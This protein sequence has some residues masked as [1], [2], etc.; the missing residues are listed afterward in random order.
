MT[1]EADRVARGLTK[2]QRAY[3]R[4][5]PDEPHWCCL[6]RPAPTSGWGGVPATL[7]RKGI[8]TVEKPRP[9]DA[10]AMKVYAFSDFGLL[11]RDKL[12][13]MEDEH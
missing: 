4:H 12:K 10:A 13:G 8:L 2:A 5:T 7:V 1:D 9:W 11:V 6:V 3:V